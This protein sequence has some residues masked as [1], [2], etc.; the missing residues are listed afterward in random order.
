MKTHLLTLDNFAFVKT[1]II[2]TWNPVVV[3]FVTFVLLLIVRTLN[4][5]SQPSK[6]KVYGRD[7]KFTALLRECAPELEEM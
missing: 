1:S 5:A 7:E 3:A 2:G 4:L 6:P